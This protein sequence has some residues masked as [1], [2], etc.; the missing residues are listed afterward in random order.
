MKINICVGG[1]FHAANLANALDANYKDKIIYTSSPKKNWPK[2]IRKNITFIPM[3][4]SILAYLFKFNNPRILKYIDRIIFDY[5]LSIIIRKS[6]ICH[7]WAG[8]G[9]KTISKIKKLD[10]K[11]KI[12]LERSCP[13]INFQKTILKNE[14]K[15]YNLKFYFDSKSDVKRQLYEYEKSDFILTC[16]NYSKNSFKNYKNLF[17]KTKVIYLPSNV[18]IPKISKI[19]KQETIIGFI[20]DFGLRK[21]IHC[22][23]NAFEKS[24]SKNLLYLKLPKLDTKNKLLLNNCLKKEFIKIKG[25][26]DSISDFYNEIDFLCIPSI[27]EGFGVVAIEAL[28][29]KVQIII[30]EGVGSSEI[31]TSLDNVKKFK[32]E[33]DLKKIFDKIYASNIKLKFNSKHFFDNQKY[34]RKYNKDI[35]HLYSKL[36]LK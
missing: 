7:I 35:C 26:Y 5:F 13:H 36:L 18:E 20:G 3:P 4:F 24:K 15:K 14:S 32:D 33:K 8:Y 6:D 17:K 34:I 23:I 1:R 25:Y 11:T 19:N 28:Q 22:L 29:H 2:K 12:I 27:D 30:R 10:P 9:Y 16:S 31:L 21:G